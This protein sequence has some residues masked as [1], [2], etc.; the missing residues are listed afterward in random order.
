MNKS[1][2]ATAIGKIPIERHS[3]SGQVRGCFHM[4]TSHQG[5]SRGGLFALAGAIA[6]VGSFCVFYLALRWEFEPIY[7]VAV[8]VLVPLVVF[9]MRKWP[10]AM[11]SG[12][13][14]VGTFKTIPADGISLK[15]PTMICLLLSA[16]AIFLDALFI[17]AR[18]TPWT[19]GALFR[20]Q[21]TVVILFLL[22]CAVIAVSLLYT[23]S[24]QGGMT[25]ARFETFEVLMFFAPILLLKSKADVRQLLITV[26]V[27]AIVMSGKIILN[28]ERPSE[29]VMSGKKDITNLV[30]GALLGFAL[31][32]CLYGKLFE[33]RIIRNA[34]IVFLSFGLIACAARSALVA[35]LISIV[36]SA[37][38]LRGEAGV[39]ARKVVLIAL[40]LTAGV[41]VPTLLWLRSVPAAQEKVRAK[42]GELESIAAG[43]R[44]KTGT[45]SQRLGF[46]RSALDA[47]KQHPIIGLGVGGWSIFYNNEDTA[48][49]PHSF[50]L[51]VGAEQGAVGLSILISLLAVLLRSALKLLHGDPY[52]AFVFPA[53]L[54]F[55]SF[56]MVTS[57]VESRELWFICG[58][59]AA[60]S[61]ISA[62]PHP[63]DHV[64]EMILKHSGR[65]AYVES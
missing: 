23:P 28:L 25:V 62:H 38:V 61:R 18:A 10:L 39:L 30:A 63:P 26:V 17:M 20:G 52:F 34:C 43:P 13:L 4:P 12:L 65:T 40:L 31:L 3:R 21:A 33:S 53:L 35:L 15:D 46:Y 60:A 44:D 45:I 58:L 14:F 32:L 59:V 56:H 27:L 1:A 41:A 50:V 29:A 5:Y 9:V 55:V 64:Q 7:T 51:E 57:T 24:V 37:C 22:F 42:V 49:Y 6:L 36:V 48:Y 8:A 47:F 2:R 16:G 54:F 19:F 11:L